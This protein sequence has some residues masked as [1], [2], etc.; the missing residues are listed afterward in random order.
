MKAQGGKQRKTE[1]LANEKVAQEI[2]A[3]TVQITEGEMKHH[4]GGL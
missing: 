3:V 2:H 4:Y 1:V